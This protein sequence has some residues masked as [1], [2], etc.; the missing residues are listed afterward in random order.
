MPLRRTFL[1]GLLK[2]RYPLVGWQFRIPVLSLLGFLSVF[3]DSIVFLLSAL[4]PF[5][6][7]SHPKTNCPV[8]SFLFS[9][10]TLLTHLFVSL[11][12]CIF[13]GAVE[14]PDCFTLPL[15]GG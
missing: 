12:N 7:V 6:P 2:M 11:I 10:F 13:K 14:G 8:F 1:L 5:L 4:I 15:G 3:L 9:F